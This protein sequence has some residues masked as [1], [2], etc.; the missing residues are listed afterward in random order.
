MDFI[1]H[2][3]SIEFLS[4]YAQLIIKN[5]EH[6]LGDKFVWNRKPYSHARQMKNI[7]RYIQAQLVLLLCPH[8]TPLSGYRLRSYAL[9]KWQILDLF[10]CKLKIKF[11]IMIGRM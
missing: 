8:R 5:L 10:T 9:R 4:Y 7:V 1:T 11:C 3:R 2:G 6:Y